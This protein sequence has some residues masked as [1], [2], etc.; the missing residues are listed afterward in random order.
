MHP[1]TEIRSIKL[2]TV[3]FARSFVLYGNKQRALSKL[4]ISRQMFKK[5]FVLDRYVIV[6]CVSGHLKKTN[7][8]GKEI[9]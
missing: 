4:T 9:L 2:L 1:K 3:F 8:S 7:K 6:L 5:L